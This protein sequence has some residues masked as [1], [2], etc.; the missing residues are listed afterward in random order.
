MTLDSRGNLYL[1]TSV[2]AVY[3][4]KGEKI[5][6]IRTPERPANVTFGGEDGRT[7]FITARTSLYAVRMRVKGA[8]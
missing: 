2:V 7:L 4:P 1:T 8:K 6:E 3:T 5:V